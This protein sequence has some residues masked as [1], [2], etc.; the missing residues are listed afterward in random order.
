MLYFRTDCNEIIAMGH[1]MRCLSIADAAKELGTDCVFICADEKGKEVITS[2][3]HEVIVLG[4]AYNNM[5]AELPALERVI[6]ERGIRNMVIDSYFV[7]E[8][9]LEKVKALK[10]ETSYIDD[11]NSF[12]Y[13]VDNIICYANYYDKFKYN[14]NY[15]ATR[16]LLGTGYAPIRKDYESLPEKQIS[17]KIKKL[18]LLTGGSNNFNFFVKMLDQLKTGILDELDSVTIVCGKFDAYY[19]EL[20]EKYGQNPK[21]KIYQSLPTLKEELTDA[22]LVITAGG[23]TL[24]E[25]CAVGVPAISYSFADNQLDNCKSFSNDGL[26]PYAGDLRT[27][28]VP[29]VA[30]NIISCLSDLKKRIEISKQMQSKV[31]GTGARKIAMELIKGDD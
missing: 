27:D 23:S 17:D 26:I 10:V 22:D 18:L 21:V 29:E 30:S 6:S 13:P 8:N 3:G 20:T 19:S 16:L 28:N 5:D 11:L 15:P 1:V 7:T 31:D 9:Y 2:R 12:I 4:T 24:Y 14:L 25:I